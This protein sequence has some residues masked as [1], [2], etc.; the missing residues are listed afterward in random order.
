V[1]TSSVASGVT[2]SLHAPFEATLTGTIA[3]AVSD[4]GRAR[5]TIDGLLSGGARG[6]VR[7]VLDGS[8]LAGGGIQMER[9]VARL[10]T[11]AQPA[12]YQGT[13]VGLDGTNL[14]AKVQNGSGTSLTLNVRLTVDSSTNAVTGSVSAR[15]GV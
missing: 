3:Q 12:L 2:E 1:R 14:R 9:S 15:G 11:A 4:D 8:A 6:S 10:G 13:V 7:F 5:V